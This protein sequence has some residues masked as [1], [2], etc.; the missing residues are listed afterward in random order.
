M[1]PVCPDEHSSRPAGADLT[2]RLHVEIK[3]HA[4]KAG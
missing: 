1:I 2:L 4:G 3:S